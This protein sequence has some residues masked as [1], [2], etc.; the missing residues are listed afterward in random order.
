MTLDACEH[1]C[2]YES[3]PLL[4]SPLSL[5]RQ[6]GMASSSSSSSSFS[7]VLRRPART[8][9]IPKAKKAP[10]DTG[11][12][13]H[14]SSL[15]SCVPTPSVAPSTPSIASILLPSG[16]GEGA[17]DGDVK[18]LAD[19]DGVG[20]FDGDAVG[21][22]DSVGDDEGATDAVGAGVVGAGVGPVEGD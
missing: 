20:A 2:N 22:C 3:T 7:S 6:L 9:T 4:E 15:F 8:T 16:E 11:A 12:Q 5:P 1:V 19:G 18:G 14:T 17:L 10:A 21:I 13:N